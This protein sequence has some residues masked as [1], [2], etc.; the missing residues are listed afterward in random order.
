M[1]Y[2]GPKKTLLHAF[3]HVTLGAGIEIGTSQ[4]A[5]GANHVAVGMTSTAIVAGLKEY[6]D[7]QTGKDTFKMTIIHAL[8]VV[9]GAGI[10]AGAWHGNKCPKIVQKHVENTQK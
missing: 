7:Y 10:A 4:A 1:A 9:G 2:A 6:A 3:E 5:G 8:E